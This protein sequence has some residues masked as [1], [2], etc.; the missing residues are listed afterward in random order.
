[1]THK[2][3]RVVKPQHNQKLIENDKNMIV[4]FRFFQ[5]SAI[6]ERSAANSFDFN[7][8]VYMHFLRC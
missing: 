3:W 2:G 4:S 5:Q 1:M 8:D 7:A 6:A